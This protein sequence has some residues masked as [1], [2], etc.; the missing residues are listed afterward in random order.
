MRLDAI[1]LQPELIWLATEDEKVAFFRRNRDVNDPR[2]VR[3]SRPRTRS[4]SFTSRFRSSKLK[5]RRRG[6]LEA[7]SC[8]SRGV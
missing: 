6:G 5:W 3:A 7:G 1:V 8:T 2:W 4:G